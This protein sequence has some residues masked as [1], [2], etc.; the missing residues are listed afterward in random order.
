MS[1]R[2]RDALDV[3]VSGIGVV[4]P[5]GP[6]VEGWFD[7]RAE[8][9]RRGYK[10]LP[11][12]S[13]YFLAAARRALAHG[14]DALAAVDPGH[15]GAAVGTNT[16]VHAVHEEIDD[17]VLRGKRGADD[18]FP[19]TAPY[20]SV[21]LFS[22]KLATEHA[23]KGFN[24][25]LTTPRVAG[26]EAIA[27]G[28][29]C[30]AADRARALVTGVAEAALGDPAA[31]EAAEAG[32]VALVLE[33]AAAATARGGR[34]HGRLAVRTAFLPPDA[35]TAG[36][37]AEALGPLDGAPVT[38]V[39]DDSPVAEAV[40]ASLGADVERV[41]AGPGAL[42]PLLRIAGALRAG[43]PP[44]LVVTAAAEGHLAVCRVAPAAGPPA[45]GR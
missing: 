7:H 28:T 30:L 16:A 24:L 44:S 18:L 13:Q 25:T 22:T 31:G 8:L 29:S 38:A 4:R 2:R 11:A 32:A 37:V 34:G 39:L 33:P 21:N 10:Y 42:E 1:A 27:T 40:A 12:A 41:P 6:P 17:T 36:A 14:G 26:L 15:R 3:V 35:L 45:D 43:G 20:F 9:G 5:E 23:V 19:P